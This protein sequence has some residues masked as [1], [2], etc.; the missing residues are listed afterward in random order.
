MKKIRLRAKREQ[1]ATAR[2][3]VMK[4]K[5][6]HYSAAA[7]DRY[8]RDLSRLIRRMIKEY[9]QALTRL[10]TDFEPMAMD[11]SFASQTRIW[12]NKLK[13]RWDSIFNKKS[14]E[15]ADK[16]VSQTDLNA[17]RNLDDSLKQLSGGLTIKTPDRPAEMQERLTAATAENVALI[18]SIPQQFHFRIESAALRSISQAGEGAKTLLD[19][20]RSIGSVT[21]KRAQFIAVDQTRKIT[22]AANYERMKSAGIRKAVWHHS[23]GSAEPRKLHQKLDGQV[24]ELDNPPIIDDRTGQRGLPGEL[25]NCKCFWTPVVDFGENP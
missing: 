25:P 18:K 17:K 19:E 1:W 5:P 8:Q 20:I 21:E 11:A 7:T 16:F 6:L 23:G 14:S 22:T 15:L 3:A 2:Q 4:G 9:Q 10:A 24:F 13:R 12:L